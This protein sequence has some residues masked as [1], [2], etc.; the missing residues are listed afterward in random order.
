[1]TDNASMVPLDDTELANIVGGLGPVLVIAITA[2]ITTVVKDFVEHVGDFTD[3]IKDGWT[4][5]A[6]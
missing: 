6:T 5:A 2:V 3:G 4:A 1:M